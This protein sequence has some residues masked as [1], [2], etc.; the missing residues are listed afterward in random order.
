LDVLYLVSLVVNFLSDFSSLFKIIKSILLLDLLVIGDLTS[1]F[2]GVLYQGIF[3]LLFD[4]SLLLF[5]L[6]LLLD[7]IHVVF[8]FDSCLLSKAQLLLAELFLSSYLEVGL[9]SH[10]L[11]SFQ[12]F[13]LSGLSLAFLESSLSTKS[14]NLSLS[15][16]G[17]FLKLSK[18]LNFLLFFLLDSGGLTLSLVF[19]FV[20]SSLVLNDGILMSLV[21]I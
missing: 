3:L 17:L 2:L 21:L 19:L 7:L 18:S 1:N 9:D 5:N 14:V 13:P 8:S 15:I 12:S 10:S 4:L 16:S 20:S 11:L 6:L